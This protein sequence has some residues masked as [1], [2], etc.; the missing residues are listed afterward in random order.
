VRDVFSAVNGKVGA[1]GEI[2]AGQPIEVLVCTAL[3]GA[4]AF[5]KIDRN[6]GLGC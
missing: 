6:P 5:G 2:L 1:L 3:P 4:G